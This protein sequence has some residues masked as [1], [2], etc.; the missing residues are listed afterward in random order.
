MIGS[1]VCLFPVSCPWRAD[2]GRNSALG[3]RSPCWVTVG[4]VPTLG[5]VVLG[6][7][8]D[9][10]AVCYCS[11]VVYALKLQESLLS[12]LMTTGYGD[13]SLCHLSVMSGWSI[14]GS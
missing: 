13:I 9:E 2:P 4:P 7:A 14:K 5:F 8:S 11:G 1:Q 6:I 3:G 12:W 10:G